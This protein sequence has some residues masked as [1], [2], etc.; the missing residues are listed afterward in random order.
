MLK[1]ASQGGATAAGG[2]GEEVTVSNFKS[3]RAGQA[4]KKIKQD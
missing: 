1:L 2:Q 4:D 3:N